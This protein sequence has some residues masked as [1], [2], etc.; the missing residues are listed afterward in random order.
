MTLEQEREEIRNGLAQVLAQSIDALRAAVVA[1]ANSEPIPQDALNSLAA[2]HKDY[3]ELRTRASLLDGTPPPERPTW[4]DPPSINK[5]ID[6]CFPQTGV[7]K[8]LFEA[9]FEIA[10]RLQVLES[11]PPITRTQLRSWLISKAQ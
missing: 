11:K 9:L 6:H 2:L 5:I 4:L 3:L 1:Q 10:N 7:A 8:A